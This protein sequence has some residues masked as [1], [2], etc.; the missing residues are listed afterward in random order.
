MK[1]SH[2]PDERRRRVRHLVFSRRRRPGA[3]LARMLV[4]LLVCAVFA[5]FGD[6]WP[7]FLG[8][9]HDASS[10]ETGLLKSWK[11]GEPKIS[12]EF[13]KGTGHSCPAI[14]GGRLVL[15]HRIEERET[16]DC[17]DAETGR[18][19]WHFDYAAPYRDRYGAGEG[20]R[21]SPV[22]AGERVFIAGITGLLHCL[23]LRDGTVI[24]K[25]NLASDYAIAPNFFGYGSTPLALGAR[26]IANIG[27]KENICCVALDVATGK[28]LWRAKHEWGA[29]YASPIPAKLHGRECVMVFAGGE[30]RP[31]IGGLLCIDAATGEVLNATPHRPT[32]AESVSASSPVVV[33]NRVFVTESY[34]SGGE[35]VEIAPDFSAKSV[36]KT[37]NFGAYF[38]TPVAK[39]GYLYGFDGQQPQLAALVCY[40]ISSGKEMWRDQLGGKFQRGSLLAVDGAFLCLGENGNLG[41][42]DLTP[43]GA[44]VLASTTLFRAPESWTL[45]ALSHGRLYVCQNTRADPGVGPRLICYDLRGKETDKK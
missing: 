13:P 11:N 1:N 2:W 29:S 5:A 33:G 7:R 42:L 43:R 31:P 12:W 35:M 41:W 16:V 32:I 14:A 9:N 4:L 26:L 17:L 36:W 28:E 23:D 38:M 39:E 21:A 24:W 45:P 18:V 8:P 6:D 37:E 15:L 10:S 40:E 25:R 20:T 19:L 22:I 3:S 27:G 34:G 30:S 44:K